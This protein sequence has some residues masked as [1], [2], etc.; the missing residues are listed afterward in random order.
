MSSQLKIVKTRLHT[1]MSQ[2]FLNLLIKIRHGSKS[3]EKTKG[4]TVYTW[5]NTRKRSFKV[6][7]NFDLNLFI[8]KVCKTYMKY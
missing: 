2:E 1:Q 5:R 3:F 8:N 7:A 6:N 4:T